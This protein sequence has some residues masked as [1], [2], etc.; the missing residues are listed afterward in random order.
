MATESELF[1]QHMRD[2]ESRMQHI[3][4]LME[5]ARHGLGKG[6]AP[7]EIHAELEE[8]GRTH[9]KLLTLYEE[10]KLESTEDWRREEIIKSGPMGIW[11]ALAQQ[12]E[13]LVERLEG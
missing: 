8:A 10:L 4:K 6:N 12:L 3:D 13:K 9:E 1:V 2:F 11:D 5:R 7:E